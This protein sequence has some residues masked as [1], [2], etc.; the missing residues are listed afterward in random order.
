MA[1]AGASEALL[2]TGVPGD[3]DVVM[4]GDAAAGTPVAVAG[5][6]ASVAAA[7]T[8]AAGGAGASGTLAACGAR[9]TGNGGG[10]TWLSAG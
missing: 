7:G 8:L 5:T 9:A 6:T 1:G 4:A 3:V 10:C 2:G